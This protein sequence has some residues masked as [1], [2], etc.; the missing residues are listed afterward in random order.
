MKTARFQD[1]L[2]PL[3][4]K[5]VAAFFEDAEVNFHTDG[6]NTRLGEECTET[7]QYRLF[8]SFYINLHNRWH[9]VRHLTND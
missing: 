4:S 2:N 8:I 1:F 9:H 3:G 6:L 5:P 7:L